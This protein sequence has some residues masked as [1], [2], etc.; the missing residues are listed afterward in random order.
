MG[1]A[2]LKLSQLPKKKKIASSEAKAAEF[3]RFIKISIQ[4]V[5]LFLHV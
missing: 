3:S 5:S 2:N 4:N 1:L